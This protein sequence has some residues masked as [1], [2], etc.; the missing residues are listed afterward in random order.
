M[1]IAKRCSGVMQPLGVAEKPWRFDFSKEGRSHA[2][3]GQSFQVVIIMKSPCKLEVVWV[4]SFK[5][6]CKQ[7]ANTFY[8]RIKLQIS[9]CL[10]KLSPQ[11]FCDR[12]R[13]FDSQ[14]FIRGMITNFTSITR[15]TCSD[16]KTPT[17]I[18]QVAKLKFS[19]HG[20]VLWCLALDDL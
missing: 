19:K 7:K 3:G 6:S 12:N 1:V 2:R 13:M 8:L 15:E 16:S 17:F 10:I 9:S 20:K 4:P 5:V 11:T 14:D 18:T